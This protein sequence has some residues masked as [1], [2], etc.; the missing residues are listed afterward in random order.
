MTTNN[1]H[2]G[3]TLVELAIV[4]VIIGLLV[5]GV[6][7]GQELIKQAQI[8]RVVRDIQS[9]TLSIRTFDMK[10]NGLP[11]DLKNATTFWPDCA[12]GPDNPFSGNLC[13]GNGNNI[14]TEMNEIHFFWHHLSRAELINGFFLPYADNNDIA[15][16]AD[17][18]KYAPSTAGKFMIAA[19]V[20]EGSAA[21]RLPPNL[22]VFLNAVDGLSMR[23]T[24][25]DYVRSIDEKFDD[26]KAGGGQMKV[27][28]DG[29]HSYN[30]TGNTNCADAATGEYIPGMLGMCNFVVGF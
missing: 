25:S 11:G 10:Y 6:L 24:E 4:L 29:A 15:T 3:F 2:K 21:F 9:Y 8:R 12:I 30:P 19:L 18:L 16:P 5:G 26:G 23:D 22:L 1:K 7:Q 13:D 17:E 14:V 28:W 20:N 27:F